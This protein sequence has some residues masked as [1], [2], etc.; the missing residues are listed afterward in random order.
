ML[1]AL[2]CPGSQVRWRSFDLNPLGYYNYL[3]LHPVVTSFL[4][5]RNLNNFR[6]P[7]PLISSVGR[8]APVSPFRLDRAFQSLLAN[9]HPRWVFA[10]Q[11]ED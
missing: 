1:L 4:R 5:A 10:K 8:S 11:S 6:S 2:S 9:A 3:G 7:L